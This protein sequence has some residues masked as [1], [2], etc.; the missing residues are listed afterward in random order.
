MNCRTVQISLSAHLDG[1]LSA[2]ETRSLIAHLDCCRDCES[3]LAQMAHVRAALGRLPVNA[4]PAH[5]ATALRV[6]ASK[7]GARIRAR[8]HPWQAAVS[9]LR[10][11][12]ENMMRPAAL[13]FAGGLVSA[14][15][16]FSMLLPTFTLHRAAGSDV[17]VAL[18]TEPSI[19]A[20][21]PFPPFE[22]DVDFIVEVTVDDQGRMVD[23]SLP[24]GSAVGSNPEFRR[25]L[26]NKLLFTEFTP[27]TTF[28]QPTYGKVY[29]S[30]QRRSIDIKS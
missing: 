27:A 28:G 22:N 17:P 7:E 18:F 15:L 11:W 4:A 2:D 12:A 24:K 30:F 10:L 23:Y 20:Q 13:P 19:K 25:A 29:V 5:L 14:I 3:R 16:L 21:M 8:R 1:A 9:S 26:E 6:I